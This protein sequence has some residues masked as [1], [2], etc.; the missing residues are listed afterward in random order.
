M[1]RAK[2]MIYQDRYDSKPW[3]A[4]KQ[5]FCHKKVKTCHKLRALRTLDLSQRQQ[6]AIFLE[7]QVEKVT[8]VSSKRQPTWYMLISHLEG[9]N[10]YRTCISCVI[11]YLYYITA[12]NVLPTF[13][14]HQHVYYIMN[15]NEDIMTVL[16]KMLH[17][18]QT[19]RTKRQLQF[20]NSQL[21]GLLNTR[22][23]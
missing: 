22:R 5:L 1:T 3:R 13:I 19:M 15:L 2:G 21:R 14:S 7:E 9:W 16:Y 8:F 17:E 10:V 23:S 6:K 12:H 11:Y 18:N 4:T 20:C